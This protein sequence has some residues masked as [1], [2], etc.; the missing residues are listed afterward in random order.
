[1]QLCRSECQTWQKGL[2]SKDIQ[3]AQH[4]GAEQQTQ[5]LQAKLHLPY[6]RAEDA[7]SMPPS[8]HGHMLKGQAGLRLPTTK[9]PDAKSG[10]HVQQGWQGLST[11]RCPGRGWRRAPSGCTACGSTSRCGSAAPPAAACRRQARLVQPGHRHMGIGL[12]MA[13][14]ASAGSTTCGSTS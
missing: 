1:M 6:V 10:I 5:D 3:A 12:Q 7:Y 14:A 2:N 4:A 11:R 9:E 8:Q 13:F